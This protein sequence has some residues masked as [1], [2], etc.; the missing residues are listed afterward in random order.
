MYKGSGTL[1]ITSLKCFDD[2]TYMKRCKEMREW[3]LAQHDWPYTLK[4]NREYNVKDMSEF[5]LRE[6][7]EELLNGFEK[8]CNQEE[9]KENL[10]KVINT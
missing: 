6:Y 4:S 2:L 9:S 3:W 1:P 5:V 10:Q 7:V 8:Y